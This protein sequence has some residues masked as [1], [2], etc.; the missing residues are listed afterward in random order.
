[1]WN[2][3]RRNNNNLTDKILK[4]KVIMD[5]YNMP[6]NQMPPFYPHMDKNYQGIPM[7]L[8]LENV[9][10]LFIYL[11]QQMEDNNHDMV[12][13]MTQQIVIILKLVLE[14]NTKSRKDE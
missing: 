5:Q 8:I 6:F 14:I 4:E 12:Y 11:L 1:M 10:I 2:R 3:S 7:G 13:V 9:A